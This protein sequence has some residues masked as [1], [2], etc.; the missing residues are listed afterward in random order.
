[1]RKVS[2]ILL[3]DAAQDQRLAV[4]VVTSVRKVGV[5]TAPPRRIWPG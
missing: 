5:I 2:E 1:L 3:D 4:V